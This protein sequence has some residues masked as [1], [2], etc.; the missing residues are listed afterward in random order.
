MP[1]VG[2][3][4]AMSEFGNLAPPLAA[5]K[6]VHH[7]YLLLFYFRFH[8]PRY[9]MSLFGFLLLDLV[10]LIDTA[11]DHDRYATLIA[12]APVALFEEA[13]R[14]Y[15]RR[16][17]RIFPGAAVETGCPKPYGRCGRPS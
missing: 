8:D 12:S 17:P 6:E 3:E 15:S 10:T 4:N 2:V 16:S 1:G 11:L 7:F 13:R 14:C 9:A 5:T